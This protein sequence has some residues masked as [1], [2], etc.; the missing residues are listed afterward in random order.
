MSKQQRS[1][2]VYGIGNALVDIEYEVTADQLRELEIEKGVMTLVDEPEQTKIMERLGG[3]ESGRG[4]G[5]SAANTIIALSQLGGK[6]CYSCS[7][8]DD[9]LGHFYLEDLRRAGIVT[10]IQPEDMVKGGITGK[11]LVL[12]TPDADRTMNTFLGASADVS[13]ANVDET[14]IGQAEYAYIE[15]YLVAGPSSKTAAVHAARQ[16]R[17]QGVKIAFSLS[18]PNI[19]HYFRPAI[20]ELIDGG[21]DLLFANE[22]E[23]KRMAE[24]DDLGEAIERMKGIAN[25]FVITRGPDGAVAYDGTSLHTIPPVPTQAVDTVGAG[26]MFAGA[27]LYGI[28]HGMPFP[29]AA[30]L[31]SQAGSR[32]VSSMGPRLTQEQLLEVL[33]Q[34]Q[35]AP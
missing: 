17:D 20:E 14:A 11:C 10:S 32:I 23:A 2:D 21:V 33:R 13:S 12:I 31:A 8:A 27:F 35:T 4:S 6:G 9:E 18:D 22:D 30:R 29:H 1:Y 19:V 28:T 16:A 3:Q 5:G 15:G 24:T 7:V 34:F 25:Q 26:D